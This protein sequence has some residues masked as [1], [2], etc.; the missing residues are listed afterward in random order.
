MQTYRDLSGA[1]GRDLTEKDS[2]KPPLGAIR[3]VD[4]LHEDSVFLTCL[5]ASKKDVRV[6]L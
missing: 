5:S 1:N 3:E 2:K 6:I 4:Y